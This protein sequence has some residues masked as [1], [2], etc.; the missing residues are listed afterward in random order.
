MALRRARDRARL[1]NAP[2]P[3][4]VRLRRK[5]TI[6]F[7]G[8]SSLLSVLLALFLYRFVERQLSTEYRERL[9]DVT[10]VGT[11]AIDLGAYERLRALHK[12]DLDEAKVSE[13]E[14]SAD[15]R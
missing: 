4:D 8:V 14:H 5:L 15:Y 10:R 12:D 11:H 6:A 13:I 3:R 2:G 1:P 7:F 9:R